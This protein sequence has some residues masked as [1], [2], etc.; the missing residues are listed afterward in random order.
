MVLNH[1][2]K[3]NKIL[4]F[5]KFFKLPLSKRHRILFK[6]KKLKYSTKKNL[7]FTHYNKRNKYVKKNT[8]LDE[9]NHC[10]K[11]NLKKKF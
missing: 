5:S 2:L 4:N 9:L 1:I 6:L 10:V 7:K 8:Y 3:T 11:I